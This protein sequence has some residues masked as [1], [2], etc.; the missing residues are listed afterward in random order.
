MWVPVCVKSID[1]FGVPGEEK[2]YLSSVMI[3]VHAILAIID[4]L[5]VIV[6]GIQLLRHHLHNK[7]IGWT[8]QKVFHCLIGAA[9]FGYFLYFILTIVA[10][11]Q[12][13]TCFSSACGFILIAAPQ[14]LFL[15]T[16]L[17]LLSFWV[18]L[19]NPA[20]DNDEEDDED[21]D[22]EYAQLPSSPNSVESGSSKPYR[23]CLPFRR[24][25]VRGRQR[26]VLMV[27]LLIFSLTVAFAALIWYGMY[28]NPIDSVK[29]AQ[30]YANFFALV[31]LL[32]GGGLA[33]YG[34]LLYTKMSRVKSSR[35]SADIK[36]V[37]GLAVASFVCFSLQAILVIISDVTG[38]NIWHMKHG[39]SQFCALM[40]FFYY[41]IGESVPSIVVLWV[42]RDLPP[43][44]CDNSMHGR[45][46]SE[47]VLIEDA[48][49]PDPNYLSQLVIS[50][51]GRRYFLPNCCN[52]DVS[53]S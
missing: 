32:S 41:F 35:A 27:V 37:T 3:L 20:N 38:L 17:L 45:V 28:D 12:G 6:A 36:K 23:T 40:I 49:V 43:R 50:A 4:L 53:P 2:F 24:W 13:W 29:L 52:S 1:A 47:P 34:L 33:G 44:S 30:V 42:M 39:D 5:I 7:R 15:A 22:S 10:T 11:C 26:C 18:D 21:I 48:L 46:A 25:R 9:N 51:A 31:I 14:T 16:F 19:C 8:R